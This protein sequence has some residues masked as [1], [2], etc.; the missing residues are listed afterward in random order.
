M[1]DDQTE[2]LL[3]EQTHLGHVTGNTVVDFSFGQATHRGCVREINED[4]MVA[5]PHSGIWVV[6]DGMGGHA[7]GDFA[8]RTVVESLGSLGVPLSIEDQKARFLLRMQAANHRIRRA[9]EDEGLGTVGATVAA[10]L[11]SEDRYTCVW[12]GDSRIYRMREGD[13]AAKQLTRD[14]VVVKPVTTDGVPKLDEEGRPV[15]RRA[16]TRAVGVRDT[17]ECDT[18]NGRVDD[19][20]MFFLCSD[21]IVAHFSDEEISDYLVETYGTP[22]QEICDRFVA[23]TLER[24]AKDN[25]TVIC[26]M[27][28]RAEPLAEID[29]LPLPDLKINWQ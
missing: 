24:G 19:G 27:L 22:P 7:R 9:S 3:E 23:Q 18:V 2:T 14:H 21:G 6:A 17:I 16:L 10:L 28:S 1:I 15:E 29:N 25:V 26:L 8:S 11:I 20:D 5:L 12:A 4:A 13:D